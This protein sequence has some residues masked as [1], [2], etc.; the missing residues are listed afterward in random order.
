M[1]LLPIVGNAAGMD[2]WQ[3]GLFLLMEFFFSLEH[4]TAVTVSVKD[5]LTLS[6]GVAVGSSIVSAF[7]LCDIYNFLNFFSPFPPSKLPSLSFREQ[8]IPSLLDGDWFIIGDRLSV[9]LSH[10]LGFLTNLLHS[11]SIHM[12]PLH[13]FCQVNN[14]ILFYLLV[15][16][17][18]F[19]LPF[20][21]ADRKLRCSGWKIKLARRF[22]PDGLV[23]F[24]F[25]SSEKL[26]QVGI[27][28]IISYSSCYILVLPR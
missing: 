18:V 17:T 16:T 21:S 25:S 23:F 10:S 13:C 19:F 26:K 1:I 27:N 6:L 20:R 12:S 28:R 9:S 14:F 22:H 8:Y 24:S 2:W 3:V 4:V 11:F 7:W 15:L 5:K